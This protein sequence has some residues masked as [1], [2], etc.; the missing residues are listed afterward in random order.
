MELRDFIVTPIVLFIVYGLA[1]WIRPRVTD[2]NTRRYFIPALTVKIIGALAVGFIYQFYYDGGGDTFA[3]HT[4]S[5]SVIWEAILTEP[6]VGLKLF[7][8]YDITEGVY[9]YAS[10]IWYYNDPSSFRIIQIAVLFDLLTTN[11]YSGTA[12]LFAVYSF[13]GIWALYLSFYRRYMDIHF[14]LAMSILFVP[15]VFFW[16]SGI[17]KDTVTLGSVGWMCF[18]VQRL[19]IERR[20]RISAVLILIAAGWL[21][22]TIKLY[23]LLAILPSFIIWIFFHY[24]SKV[25]LV[26]LRILIMPLLTLIILL[27]SY[28]VVESISSD[29][30]RYSLDHLAST[31][32]MTAYD[33]R[34]GWGARNGQGSG[35]FLGEL[36]G[37]FLGS[38]KYAPS[39][40]NVSLFRP[41]LWE[42]RNPLMLLSALESTI[43]LALTLLTIFRAGLLRLLSKLFQADIFFTLSFSLIFAFAVGLSTFNFGTL[44]RYK[45]PLVPFFATGLVLIN[46]RITQSKR[47]KNTPLLAPTE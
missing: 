27:F 19:F 10:R 3:Y 43:L 41:Y 46:Y 40:I 45:I 18:A 34:F 4:R 5:S 23:I 21:I 8:N 16:G 35:Y 31:A 38:L 33:I 2:I 32:A 22:F 9:N 6:I 20:F 37:T 14:W 13:S 30:D 17:L 42:V 39:A 44:S 12:V 28:L 15:T 11:S 36:D 7:L 1:Y 24:M 25:R 26:V 47:D 29:N